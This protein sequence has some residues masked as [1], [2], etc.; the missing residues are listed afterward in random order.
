MVSLNPSATGEVCSLCQEGKQTNDMQNSS[1]CD[2]KARVY[3][4]GIGNLIKITIERPLR[5]E[6]P[7]R[8]LD[9]GQEAASLKERSLFFKELGLGTICVITTFAGAVGG[10]MA[11]EKAIGTND[12]FQKTVVLIGQTMIGTGVL[13]CSSHLLLKTAWIK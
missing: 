10:G 7:L 6:R 3:E 11:L 4:I 12:V 9:K 8:E 5:D 1:K 2:G 13:L